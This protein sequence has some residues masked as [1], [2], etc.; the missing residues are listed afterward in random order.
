MTSI[1]Q[2]I[3][4]TSSSWSSCSIIFPFQVTLLLITFPIQVTLLLI[5]FPIQVT[6]MTKDSIIHV[7]VQSFILGKL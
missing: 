1:G 4:Q 7:H 5:I 3:E 6:L 2:M